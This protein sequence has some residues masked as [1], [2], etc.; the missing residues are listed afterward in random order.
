MIWDKNIGVVAVVRNSKSRDTLF[1][2]FAIAISGKVWRDSFP[3]TTNSI[4]EFKWYQ[5][6]VVVILWSLIVIRV[7]LI[8]NSKVVLV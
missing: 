3:F 8:D 2:E 5:E 1:P 6:S 7:G 4:S